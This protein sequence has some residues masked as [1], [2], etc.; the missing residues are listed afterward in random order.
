MNRMIETT[1]TQ[2][3]SADA[4]VRAKG[5]REKTPLEFGGCET[6]ELRRSILRGASRCRLLIR[7]GK[8]GH[9]HRDQGHADRSQAHHLPLQVSR[10]WRTRPSCATEATSVPSRLN[11]SPRA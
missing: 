1:D 3:P 7:R 6:G 5:E 2:R 11:I 8:G 4:Q 10:F 9:Q